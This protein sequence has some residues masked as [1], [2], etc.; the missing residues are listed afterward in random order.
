MSAMD[1]ISL[2]HP[3]RLYID[4]QWRAPAAGGRLDIISPHT[5]SL[6]C[7]VAAAGVADMD[8]AVIAAR[9]AFDSGPWPRL[10]AAERAAYL[11][12]LHA[13]LLPRAE[14]L[15]QALTLQNG[16]LASTAPMLTGLSLMLLDFYANGAAGFQF[17]EPAQ[18]MDGQGRALIVHEP[19]GVAAIIVPWNAPFS[20]LI[21]KVAPALLAGCTVIMKPA[22][23]T[24]LEAFILAEAAEE[25]GLPPGV[26]NLLPAGPEASDH[27][28]ANPGIDKVSF[29]GSTATGKRIAS[30]C[31][32][33]VARHTL[34][35]GGKSA[36]ILLDDYDLQQAARILAQTIT[37]A[38][39]QV[40][41]TLSRV[42]VSRQ[43][44]AA[45]VE[46]LKTE[47]QAIKVGDPLDPTTQMG[48]L[49][50]ERQLARVRGYIELGVQ[51]GA[52]LVCGGGRPPGLDRGYYVEP[53]LF[54][55]VDSSMRIA[56][57][58]I[59]GP[60][61]CVLPCEDEADAVRIA[62]DSDY[63]LYGA[64]F[65][66]DNAKAYSI[67]RAVRTGTMSQNGF[68]AD[69]FLPFGGFKQ[70]GIGRE[71]GV[72]GLR[73]FTETKVILLAE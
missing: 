61:L 70:S 15:S 35:M 11:K 40:C 9:R 65:T 24:P 41:A 34:E 63:G 57:E 38:C 27:L 37:M 32:Q 4:G 44:Q 29:T 59:F 49:A 21:N 39:G 62:N 55:D 71:G 7:S 51:E 31:A 18:P 69:F 19:V 46:A 25:V 73:S 12:Q 56:R 3:E 50:M 42:I 13:A 58:E 52:T 28:V 1:T 16:T 20:I 10:S 17:E 5:E 72:S 48:P 6:A 60:V 22:P 14:S 47:L 8:L 66:H 45:L 33:R 54:A 64:V 30:L 53:T 36:A 68:R 23:E 26:L 67:A 43:R 2:R